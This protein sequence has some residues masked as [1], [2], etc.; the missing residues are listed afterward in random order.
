MKKVRFAVTKL[1]GQANQYWIDVVK[2]R[3]P[4][5]QEPIDTW[6][7]MKDKLKG[8]YVPSNYT[9]IFLTYGAKFLMATNLPRNMLTNSMSF[10]IV[11]IS[12][13]DRVMS[14]SFPY[15]V[16]DSE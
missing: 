12:Q 1:I 5:G 6:S 3:V 2:R 10:S 4:C 13:A 11:I 15:F 8:K 9:N 16:L 7:Y 14:K